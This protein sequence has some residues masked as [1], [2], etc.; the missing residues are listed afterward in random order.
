[1]GGSAHPWRVADGHITVMAEIPMGIPFMDQNTYVDF[2]KM[3]DADGAETVELL[4]R[5]KVDKAFYDHSFGVTQNAEYGV[6][7]M[8]LVMKPPSLTDTRTDMIDRFKSGIFEGIAVVDLTLGGITQE[9]KI[10]KT[11]PF[12]HLHTANCRETNESI[13]TDLTKFSYNMFTNSSAARI[14]MAMQKHVRD[15]DMNKAVVTRLET[16]ISGPK[17]GQAT[18]RSLSNPKRHMD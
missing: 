13:I 5:M 14:D 1:M 8:N 12:Y 16:F 17:A 3:Y 9:P 18:L 7:P 2:I 6:Y 4:A 15:K 11:E 10:F